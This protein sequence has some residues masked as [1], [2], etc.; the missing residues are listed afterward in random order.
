MI[1]GRVFYFPAERAF[2]TSHELV[3]LPHSGGRQVC[4]PVLR[5]PCPVLGPQDLR[6]NRL[7]PGLDAVGGVLETVVASSGPLARSA[8]PGGVALAWPVLDT[9]T[10][11]YASAGPATRLVL[12]GGIHATA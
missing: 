9:S 4:S 7:R 6:S 10:N 12:S 2:P 5:A 8:G 1:L 3:P 11:R